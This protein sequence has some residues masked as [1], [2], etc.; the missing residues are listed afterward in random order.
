MVKKGMK[1]LGTK[2]MKKTMNDTTRL[3]RGELNHTLRDEE[4]SNKVHT[5]WS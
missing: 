1:K 4:N 3:T 2:L 5:I